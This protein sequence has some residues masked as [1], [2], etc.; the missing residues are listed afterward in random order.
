MAWSKE[1]LQEVAR[2]CSRD[3]IC[4]LSPHKKFNLCLRARA[5]TI[6]ECAERNARIYPLAG[7]LVWLGEK[8][9]FWPLQGERTPA[10][11]GATAP[12][13]HRHLEL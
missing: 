7:T 6:W 1:K 3:R 12:Q 4:T 9:H 11:G 10:L 5:G 2:F 13:L 8:F